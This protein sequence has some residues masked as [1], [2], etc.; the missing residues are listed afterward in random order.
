MTEDDDSSLEVVEYSDDDEGSST[1]RVSRARHQRALQSIWMEQKEDHVME[2]NENER[3]NDTVN[4][5]EVIM[6]SGKTT[7]PPLPESLSSVHSKD[8]EKENKLIQ[9]HD[10]NVMA[11]EVMERGS[12]ED[13][14]SENG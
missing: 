4:T 3:V 5:L 14:D 2:W 13:M 6:M 11:M 10:T 7:V 1:M 12:D 8:S 9:D